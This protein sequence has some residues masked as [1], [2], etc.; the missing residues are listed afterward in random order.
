[1]NLCPNGHD[2]DLVGR[3]ARG[4]CKECTRAAS[5]RRQRENPE[6]VRASKRRWREANPAYARKA[7]RRRAGILGLPETEARPGDPCNL[8]GSP[9]LKKVCADHDHTTRLFRGWVCSRCNIRLGA[10]DDAAWM[11]QASDYL[12]R[13]NGKS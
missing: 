2:R 8:C 12:E 3:D 9:I 1:M 4:Y 10:L 6:K 11:K 13:H 5:R 7:Q